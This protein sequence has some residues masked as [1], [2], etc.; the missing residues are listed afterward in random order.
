MTEGETDTLTA[1]EL[2]QQ[3][4]L[5]TDEARD[6]MLAAKISQAH[7]AKAHRGPEPEFRVGDKVMLAIGHWQ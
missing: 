6:T 3:M 5:M 4:E 7:H 2:V 1:R